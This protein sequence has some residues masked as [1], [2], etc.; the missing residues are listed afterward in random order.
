M[1]L[2]QV[3]F[4]ITNE[5]G[6]H[7]GE[8][9]RIIAEDGLGFLLRIIQC[10]HIRELRPRIRNGITFQRCLVMRSE[11][12]NTA[13]SMTQSGRYTVRAGVAAAK[14]NDILACRRHKVPVF[15][16]GIEVALD[17]P[18]QIIHRVHNAI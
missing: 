3:A 7:D 13:A 4:F 8:F 17:G 6:S 12:G 18:I 2:L 15:Q 11:L 16:I 9:T 5:F 14:H 1:K 10:I